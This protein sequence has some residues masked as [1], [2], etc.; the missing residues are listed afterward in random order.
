MESY[1]K[2]KSFKSSSIQCKSSFKNAYFWHAPDKPM[3]V[4]VDTDNSVN[5][6]KYIHFLTERL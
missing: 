6:I 5:N 3:R 2:G 4:A 1:T